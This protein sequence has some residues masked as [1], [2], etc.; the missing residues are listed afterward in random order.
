MA[1]VG[2]ELTSTHHCDPK[3]CDIL[4]TFDARCELKTKKR[5]GDKTKVTFL[6]R[7][8]GNFRTFQVHSSFC[9]CLICPLCWIP[10]VQI[11]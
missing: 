11:K 10:Y 8:F 3:H 1:N 6:W 4:C 2:G 7:G 9:L 5:D